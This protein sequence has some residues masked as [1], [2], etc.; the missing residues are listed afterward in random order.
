MVVTT[1]CLENLI[2][3]TKEEIWFGMLIKDTACQLDIAVKNISSLGASVV[4]YYDKDWSHDIFS[5]ENKNI[6][7]DDVTYSVVENKDIVQTL[8]EPNKQSQ[9]YMFL[10]IVICIMFGIILYKIVQWGCDIYKNH[11]YLKTS[12]YSGDG[13]VCTICIEEFK[14]GETVRTLQCKHI[15]H[16]NCIDEWFEKKEVCPNCNQPL[17]H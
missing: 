5:M 6:A 4:F 16:K 9:T 11:C 13:D 17:L 2:I 15:F 3:P 14:N 12:A 1:T 10:F 7:I 8:I